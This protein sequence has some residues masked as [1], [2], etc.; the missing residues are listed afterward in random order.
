MNSI[1]VLF[2]RTLA[3]AFAS[4]L[5]FFTSSQDRRYICNMKSFL[6]SHVDKIEMIP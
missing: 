6:F 1:P 2:T 4:R 3:F 5:Y